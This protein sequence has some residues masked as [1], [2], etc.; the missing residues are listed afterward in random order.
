MNDY[1]QI[2]HFY[3][4]LTNLA[5]G[6]GMASMAL[7][8]GIAV[9]KGKS[10]RFQWLSIMFAFFFGFGAVSRFLRA[11]H[12]TYLP[13]TP[14]LVCDT[15]IAVLAVFA[16]VIIWPLLRRAL[17]EP[18][19]EELA[20]YN[21]QRLNSQLVAIVESTQDAV[22]GK[23][24]NGIITAWNK[25]AEEMYGYTAA[26]AIGQDISMLAPVERKTEI[27]EI[28]DK[29][30]RGVRIDAL[31]TKRITKA[32]DTRNV[33]ISVSPVR[34]PDQQIIGAAVITRDITTLKKRE[35]EIQELNDTLK[36]RVYELAEQSAE[37]QA[38]RDQALEAS[39]L[40]SA[41]CANI[42]HELRTP[43]SGI[44]GLN[45]MLIE[46]A[47]LEDDDRK[48]ALMVQQSA[49]ALLTVVNDILDLSK[50]EAG[51]ITLEYAPFNPVFLLQD[52]TRLMAPTAQQKGL[53]YQ[54]TL[55]QMLP[56]TVYG[57]VSRLRQVLL[58][59]IGNGIKFTENGTVQVSAKLL[60]SDA[61][62]A[63]IEFAV[64]D[65]GIG[66][67]PEDQRFLFMPFAQVDNSSTRRFGGTGL[68]LS[69]SKQFVQMMGGQIGV[70]SEKGQGSRFS[71]KVKFDRKKLHQ[72]ENF[73][74]EQMIKPAVAPIATDLAKGRAVLVVE[75]NSILQHLAL[76]QLNSLG[77]QAHATV[78]GHDA[79]ELAMTDKF[80]L[81]LMDINLP[82]INGLEATAAIRNLEHSA[83][84]P[85]IPI[86][87]MTA[88]AMS[89]DRER[90]L[91]AG[92]N[93][94]LAKP[95]AIE[96]LKRTVEHWLRRSRIRPFMQPP[97]SDNAA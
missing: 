9:L 95:V 27:V 96:N 50:I 38:A 77:V 86:I 55:D 40:K 16:G 81:I 59:L 52:C 6:I 10:T 31:E 21:W 3:H 33:Q 24:L 20:K 18:T 48:L 23:D 35:Q 58:N 11:L 71:F 7:A 82:D 54:L 45:E 65:T 17:T 60:E 8:I 4:L 1:S 91:T 47:K 61:D 70:K 14:E 67:S 83:N 84:R 53:D 30:K 79:I 97:P 39:N 66:V 19:Y 36:K 93:D 46:N 56:E 57:D 26:E 73:S 89:G 22:V 80:D 12:P 37:L 25:G 34:D 88:G 78:L 32:G 76:R 90:A 43:L 69:I 62:F 74:T 75:D 92:M 41:F 28:L 51:K 68:G 2:G 87:A 29:V 5:A 63:V 15:A 72:A 94:Y 49:E 44:L 64:Q 85:P 42:S 13:S